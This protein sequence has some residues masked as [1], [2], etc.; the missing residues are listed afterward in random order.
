MAGRR[1][2]GGP[3]LR[4]LELF[5]ALAGA[6]S[7]ASAGARIGM[8]PSATSHALRALESTLGATLIDRRATRVELTHAG[9]QVLPHAR[10]L[11]ATL[12][13][14]QSTAAASAGLRSGVLKIGS[15]G[16]SASLRLLP[17]LL[18][19]FRDRYPGI[20]VYVTERLDAEI[21]QRLGERRIEL[22]VITQD[23]RGFE[24]IVLGVDELVAVLPADHP[25]ARA[26]TI[27]LRRMA[28]EPMILT[29]AGSQA[30]VARMF[31][32]AE[33]KPRITHELTQLLSILAFVAR[34][35]GV[36]VLASMA[37]PDHYEGVVY[38]RILPRTTRRIALACLDARRLSPAAQ[39]FWRLARDR[40]RGR[41]AARA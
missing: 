8:S 25:A 1:E 2:A 21:R 36:S 14:I 4:Q 5:V 30:F 15:F 23:H 12:H 29:H 33:L 38:R 18:S 10:D 3:T 32:R 40:A 34:G 17:P 37:L 26:E 35:E 31:E 16:A 24:T 22:G 41:A 6:D 39:A 19:A 27:D 20:E 13:L 7:I 28:A 9:S 11:F